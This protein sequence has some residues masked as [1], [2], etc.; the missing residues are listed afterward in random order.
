[1]KKPNECEWKVFNFSD[2]FDIK[3]GFYNKKPEMFSDGDLPF[4]GATKTNN[5]ITGFTNLITVNKT[6]KT[7]DNNNATIDKKIFKGPCIA[8]TNNGSVG[9]AYFQPFD[10][11]CSHDINPLYL[12]IVELT[13]NIAMFLIVCIERQGKCFEYSRKWRPDRMVNSKILLPIDESGNPDWMYMEEYMDE[14]GEKLLKDWKENTDNLL[15]KEVDVLE[16]FSS[17]SWKEF[18]LGDYFDFKKGN[19]NKMDSLVIGGK[20]PLVSAKKIDNGLKQLVE[21]NGKYIYPRNTISLNLDGDGGAGLAFYQPSAYL[22]DSH[23][24]SLSAKNTDID[25][26]ALLFV[27]KAIS[28]QQ[29]KYGHGYSLNEDRINNFLLMLPI[30]KNG[31]P[32]WD[33]MSKY[34]KSIETKQLKCFSRFV[35]KTKGNT[36]I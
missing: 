16:N 32:Y 21:S 18:K 7:G 13:K 33:Y 17:L 27:T 23:C 29:D 35:E 24:C 9:H 20:L 25:K 11:T 26:Y 12:K 10:F 34:M 36:C 19:Q 3:K 1:M 2:I 14:V 6:S 30:D 31:N 28:M 15:T 4:L 22:L 8:V 5:G